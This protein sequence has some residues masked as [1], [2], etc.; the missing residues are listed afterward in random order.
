M[1]TPPEKP[2]VIQIDPRGDV[3][4]R[5]QHPIGK[6]ETIFVVCSRTLARVSPL[7]E[8]SLFS[9]ESEHHRQL[10]LPV[11]MDR[12][13]TNVFKVILHILHHNTS[14]IPTCLRPSD[15]LLFLT[16]GKTYQIT[17]PLSIWGTRFF[18]SAPALYPG[19]RSANDLVYRMRCANNL[20]LSDKFHEFMRDV[21]LK[22]RLDSER[23][24]G[25]ECGGRVVNIRTL[26]LQD[27]DCI[28][29][30]ILLH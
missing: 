5:V 1:Q 26:D 22:M 15:L 12:Q 11:S 30:S 29:M 8:S 13:R 16:L 28:G 19:T 25:Y 6:K 17:S 2:K 24:F 14:K 27:E 3:E 23:N 10:F 20:G 9:S 4:I 21:A 18:N 7:W